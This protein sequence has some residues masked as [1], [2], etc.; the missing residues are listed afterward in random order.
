MARTF[1]FVLH[2]VG[3]VT[4]TV[5]PNQII[6]IIIIIIMNLQANLSTINN[7]KLTFFLE[8]RCL[9]LDEKLFE[10]NRLVQFIVSLLNRCRTRLASMIL[11]IFK[12][13][14]IMALWWRPRIFLSPNILHFDNYRTTQSMK[15]KFDIISF[16]Q[17][18]ATVQI[19]VWYNF[20]FVIKFNSTE[21]IVCELNEWLNSW[22]LW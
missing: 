11:I 16:Y 20:H 21:M 1:E 3:C 2:F 6:I 4:V 10:L 19:P 14:W 12:V 9:S 18:F 13:V 17:R 5:S 7:R 15:H 22:T 8:H